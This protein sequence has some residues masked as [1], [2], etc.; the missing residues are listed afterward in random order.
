MNPTSFNLE[1]IVDSKHSR[2][3]VLYTDRTD[4]EIVRC[5]IAY[6]ASFSLQNSTIREISDIKNIANGSWHSLESRVSNYTN[7]YIDESFVDDS[8][9]QRIALSIVISKD[10][11]L[12]LQ[13]LLSKAAKTDIIVTEDADCRDENGKTITIRKVGVIFADS[14]RQHYTSQLII[15]KSAFK[16][17]HRVTQKLLHEARSTVDERGQLS[18]WNFSVYN[19][20]GECTAWDGKGWE[21]ANLMLKQK[22]GE[23]AIEV[24]QDNILLENVEVT[25]REQKQAYIRWFRDPSVTDWIIKNKKTSPAF[26]A[27]CMCIDPDDMTSYEKSLWKN[28][29]MESLNNVFERDILRD[30]RVIMNVQKRFYRMNQLDSGCC[31]LF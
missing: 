6:I 30:M 25:T 7:S 16:A 9:W 21:D 15:A 29:S 13:Q 20:N 11:C 18:L 8:C 1:K 23:Y 17:I 14:K 26:L 28:F 22:S 5:I 19:E 24:W 27:F 3:S 31:A 10:K 2:P 4:E 12:R